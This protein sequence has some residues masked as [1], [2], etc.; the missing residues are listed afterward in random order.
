MEKYRLKST[1][2]V[3]SKAQVIGMNADK[4]LPQVWTDETFSILGVDPVERTEIPSVQ[5]PLKKVVQG[6]VTNVSGKWVEVWE[7]VDLFSDYTNTDGVLVSKQS[8][9][10]AFLQSLNNAEAARV[11]SE[12]N[13][14]LAM[15][16]WTQVA[17]APVDKAA[18]ATYRQ[19]LRDVASQTGFPW[20]IE[21]PE[22]P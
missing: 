12:R 22:T 11:R 6:A 3:I 1:G 15:T 9:E 4:S 7:V 19:A 20:T 2:E 16:D 13:S 10:D 18:W 21:W 8:Q 14:K 17:D 5:D